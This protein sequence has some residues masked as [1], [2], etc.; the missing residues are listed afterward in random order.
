[1]RSRLPVKSLDESGVSGRL[2]VRLIRVKEEIDV[3]GGVDELRFV[4]ELLYWDSRV[5]K[6]TR[7]WLCEEV[8]LGSWWSLELGNCSRGGDVSV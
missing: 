3:G 6:F 4:F 2:G 8:G 1:M 7:V 5:S